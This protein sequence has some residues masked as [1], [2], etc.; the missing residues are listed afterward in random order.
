MEKQAFY[1]NILQLRIH[2]SKEKTQK[3]NIYLSTHLQQEQEKRKNIQLDPK[4]QCIYY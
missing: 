4:Q 1:I 2:I 3:V